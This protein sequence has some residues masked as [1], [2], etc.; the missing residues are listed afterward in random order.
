MEEVNFQIGQTK[1]S[2][3]VER[4]QK[5]YELYP[6]I[7][8]NCNCGDC[9]YYENVV[10]QKDISLFVLLRNMGVDLARQKEDPDH[11]WALGPSKHYTKCYQGIYEVVGKLDRY[12]QENEIVE[13]LSIREPMTIVDNKEGESL[14]YTVTQQ[15]DELLSFY[16]IVEF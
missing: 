14:Q 9:I 13:E 1:L 7:S 11:V 4:T 6:R 12:T 16:F 8:I 5:M 15:T 3:D 10:I 2:V